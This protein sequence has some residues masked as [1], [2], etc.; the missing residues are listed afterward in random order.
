[1]SDVRV[2]ERVARN[3]AL[4]LRFWDTA[5]ATS[6]VDGL[7]VEVFPRANPRARTIAQV[8]RSGVYVAHALP[9]TSPPPSPREFEFTDAPPDVLWS[10]ATRA[11]RV[12]VTD[13][14]GRFLPI[15][16]DADLPARGL[17]TWRAPW[18]SPPQLVAPTGAPGSPLQFLVEGVPL[19]SDPSRPVPEPLAVVYAHV[20]E[21]GTARE[22]AWSLLTV[23]IDDAVRGV[24]L[25][26][27]HGRVAVMFPYPEPP[28]MSLASPPE[29][30]N[31][32]TWEIAVSAFWLATSPPGPAPAI[33]DLADVF[34]SLS[35]P[36]T[37][38]EST[39]SPAI[40]LRLTYREPLTAR[41]AGTAGA[42]PSLLLVS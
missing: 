34:A 20:H 13:P 36:R 18:L 5:A 32:F 25:A 15:A 28:R 33:A 37:V 31:D 10:A 3:A 9:V 42:D 16:F 40:P 17:F 35:A 8:T 21:L 27:A 11:Y 30:R 22:A 12:E 38:I 39:G 14:A 19:F 26:D 2:L 23:A 4:G 6:A 41:T 7:R 29:A 1:V 24:G